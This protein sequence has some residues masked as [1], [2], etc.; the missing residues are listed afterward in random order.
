MTAA[1]GISSEFAR[2]LEDGQCLDTSET[3]KMILATR[4]KAWE[5]I[6]ERLPL[7]EDIHCEDIREFDDLDGNPLGRMRTFTGPECHIDWV[8][9]SNIGNPANTFTNIHL[10]I[11]MKGTT[12]IPHLGLAFG[13]LPEVFFYADIMPRY[14]LVANPKHCSKYFDPINGAHLAF[15]KQLRSNGF[16]GLIPEMPFIRSSLSPCPIASITTPE[17]YRDH[18]EPAIFDL[19]E[20]WIGLVEH[21]RPVSDATTQEFLT[22]RDYEQRRNI[23][24]L[25]PANAIA[26]RLVGKDAADRLIRIL[27]GEERGA[28]VAQSEA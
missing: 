25:D 8:I 24:Y 7:I 20:Y 6:S 9:H 2:H 23:V 13:T 3:F 14:E 5:T 22:K 18:A 28:E 10:T 16:T 1:N 17:F 15:G 12:D 27:A 26:E 19:V 4:D 21:A 11:W